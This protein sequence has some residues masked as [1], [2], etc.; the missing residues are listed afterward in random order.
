MIDICPYCESHNTF[1]SNSE[2]SDSDSLVLSF[3][4]TDCHKDYYAYLTAME[5]DDEN[6]DV[7]KYYSVEDALWH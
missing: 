2:W 7:V 6:G 4:C 1:E 3:V 5:I